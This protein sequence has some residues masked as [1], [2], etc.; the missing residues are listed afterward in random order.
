MIKPL[1]KKLAKQKAR[2]KF[3]SVKLREGDIAI[4]CGANVGEVTEHLCRSGATVYSFEPNPH[5]FKYLK[6]RFSSN[7]NVHCIQKGVFNRNGTMKLYSHR[8]SDQDE[9]QWSTGS[10]MLDYKGNVLKDKY[11][12]IPVIDLC[13]F[14]TSLH[15]RIRLIKMDVEGVEGPI[16][17]KLINTG[18]INNIDHLFV[19]THDHKIPEL[20]PETDEIRRIIK[21]RGVSNVNLNWT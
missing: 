4:D 7:R 8:L 6:E 5:A 17:K 12:E 10:S 9:L 15:A 21:K 13:E 3:F 18:L 14:I 16:L 20:K 1:L 11:H 19:E 2:R